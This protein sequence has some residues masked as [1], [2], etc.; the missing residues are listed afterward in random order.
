MARKP[1]N[2]VYGVDDRP[3][4]MVLAFLSAQHIFVMSSTLVLPVV[5]VSEI[6]GSAQ[7]T[8]AAVAMTMLWNSF[9]YFVLCP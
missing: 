2:L 9:K 3:P 8:R 6:G 4:W 1:A 5:L 7:Q